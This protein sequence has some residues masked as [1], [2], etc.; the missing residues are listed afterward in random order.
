MHGQNAD[1]FFDIFGIWKTLESTGFVWQPDGSFLDVQHDGNDLIWQIVMAVCQ[2]PRF[3]C[4]S[5]SYK[6]IGP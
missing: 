4:L 3:L 1:N 2:V 6:G 5:P